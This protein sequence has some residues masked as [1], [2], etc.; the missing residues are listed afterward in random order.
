MSSRR[1]LHT[2]P[3]RRAFGIEIALDETT[4]NRGKFYDHG[5]VDACLDLFQS[6]KVSFESQ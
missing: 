4:R 6:E 2:G 5:V 1:C 3:Y